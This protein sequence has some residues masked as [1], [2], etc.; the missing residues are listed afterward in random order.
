[1]FTLLAAA[2][3]F[4][5]A[6]YIYRHKKSGQKMVCPLDSDCDKVV[7]SVYSTFLTVPLEKVGI[8]YYIFVFIGTLAL[9]APLPA[10]LKGGL[11]AL[12][13]LGSVAAFLFSFYLTSIQLIKIKEWCTWCLTSALMCLII[14]IASLTSL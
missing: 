14:F 11:R 8:F 1:M 9:L 3:G 7:R 6:L 10:E 4:Y 12:I 2:V 5:I 13:T